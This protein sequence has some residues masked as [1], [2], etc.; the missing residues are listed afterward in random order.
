MPKDI[1]AKRIKQK[2]FLSSNLSV[3]LIRVSRTRNLNTLFHEKPQLNSQLETIKTFWRKR[4]LH[5]NI[6]KEGALTL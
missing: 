4:K 3:K 6:F 1:H 5:C 2:H